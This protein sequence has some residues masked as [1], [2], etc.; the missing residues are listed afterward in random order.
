MGYQ[1]VLVPVSGKY[2]LE[3]AMLSLEQ[4]LQIVRQDGE[5][6][7]LHCVDEA[8]YLITREDLKKLVMGDAREA[9]KLL[10]PLVERVRDAGIAYSV[11]IMEGSPVEHIP[12]FAL[13]RTCDAVVMY[14]G[15]RDE[16]GKLV[17]KLTMGGVVERVFHA[18]HIP[19]VLVR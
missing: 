10:S 7:F 8:R 16:M 19:L 15:G 6:C 11:H 18:I 17:G 9:E 5:I 3:R 4:A 1:K 2:R 13:E 14:A 12:R